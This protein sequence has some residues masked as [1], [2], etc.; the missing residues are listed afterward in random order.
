M[1][2]SS[3]YNLLVPCQTVCKCL[4]PQR[5]H[6]IKF[7][8]LGLFSMYNL[9]S[10]VL[11]WKSRWSIFEDLSVAK[12]DGGARP[13]IAFVAGSNASSLQNVVQ[14]WS[15]LASLASGISEASGTGAGSISTGSKAAGSRSIIDSTDGPLSSII[16][17]IVAAEASEGRSSS[18]SRSSSNSST[19]VGEISVSK[20]GPVARRIVALVPWWCGASLVREVELSVSLVSQDWG[21][22]D[23]S[24]GAKGPA[25]DIAKE[26]SSLGMLAL[27]VATDAVAIGGGDWVTLAITV[28]K[29]G[30]CS[31]ACVGFQCGL[32]HD[33]L[34]LSKRLGQDGRQNEEYNSHDFRWGLLDLAWLSDI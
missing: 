11:H 15:S 5:A 30:C 9:I 14:G 23:I 4:A 24:A 34:L 28:L 7:V 33:F 12:S 2:L 1:R 22:L 21:R 29:R 3:F 16:G 25:G 18:K 8:Q 13:G 32:P 10:R 20:V 17:P 26:P 27:A 31:G 6:K 19:A